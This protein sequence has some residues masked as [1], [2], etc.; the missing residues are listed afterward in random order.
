MVFDGETEMLLPEATGVPE[1]LP[2]YH[3]QVAPAP[4]FP[5]EILMVDDLPAQMVAGLADAETA[6]CEV[7]RTVTV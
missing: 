6:G 3:S 5:P 7:S 2:L 4:S 1:Q